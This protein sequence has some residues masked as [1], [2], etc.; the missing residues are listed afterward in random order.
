MWWG[1][2]HKVRVGDNNQI[3]QI[4]V[5]IH[6]SIYQH[7]P[8]EQARWEKAAFE[9]AETSEQNRPNDGQP[10]ASTGWV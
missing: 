3:F 4:K 8:H 6:Q 7:V 2:Q 1:D 5:S 9:Q 10:S